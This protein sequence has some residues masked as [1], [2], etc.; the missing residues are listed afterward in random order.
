MTTSTED[1]DVTEH[2]RP[3]HHKPHPLYP[4]P[5]HTHPSNPVP[6]HNPSRP[7]MVTYISMG[8]PKPSRRAH[9]RSPGPEVED[10]DDYTVYGVADIDSR[11]SS[12]A[13]SQLRQMVLG[14]GDTGSPYQG[15]GVHR[16]PRSVWGRAPGGR[17]ADNWKRSPPPSYENVVNMIYIWIW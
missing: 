5:S 4:P 10:D 8:A 14:E 12:L 15:A 13:S 16:A 2:P 7:E 6:S 17:T 11:M 9:A 3:R 1:D